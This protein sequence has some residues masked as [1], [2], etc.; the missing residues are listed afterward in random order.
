MSNREKLQRVLSKGLKESIDRD[1]RKEFNEAKRLAEEGNLE[2]QVGYD[3][4]YSFVAYAIECAIESLQ[5]DYGEDLEMAPS[6]QAGVGMNEVFAS[7]FRASWDF[8]YECERLEEL[9]VESDSVEEY[10]NSVISM[11]HMFVENNIEYYDEDDDYEDLDES[12]SAKKQNQLTQLKESLGTTKFDKIKSLI[13]E[14]LKEGMEVEIT[15]PKDKC[16]RLNES[17]TEE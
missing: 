4:D 8:E 5:E 16:K 3:D 17:L 12:I 7:D 14:C 13:K 9:L 6:I 1:M 2:V 15:I 11:Y 10:V